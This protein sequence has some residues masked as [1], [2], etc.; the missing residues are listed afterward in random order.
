LRLLAVFGNRNLVIIFIEC[1]L[2]YA[3]SFLETFRNTKDTLNCGEILE[4]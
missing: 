2:F 1:P 3:L 4:I